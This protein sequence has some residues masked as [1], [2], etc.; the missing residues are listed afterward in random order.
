MSGHQVLNDPDGVLDD[1]LPLDREPHQLLVRAVLA[2]S[3]PAALAPADC[4]QIALQL[5][6]H[7]RIVARDVEQLAG[8][9]PERD[10]RRLF[11]EDVLQSARARLAT[12]LE[13]NLRCVQGRA[14]IVPDL[15]ARL[16]RLSTPRPVPD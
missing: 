14:R 16:D 10:G 8:Q 6:G 9:L 2:V 11:A 12:P 7:A 3:D 1:E 5:T 15:Y 4:T 13:P